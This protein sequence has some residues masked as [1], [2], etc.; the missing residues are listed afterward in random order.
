[1]GDVVHRTTAELNRG[2]VKLLADT[3]PGILVATGGWRSGKTWGI[4]CK[5]LDLSRREIGGAPLLFGAP[6]WAMVEQVFV[7]ALLR[8]CE[9]YKVHCEWRPHKKAVTLYKRHP[10]TIYCRSLDNPRAA[11]GLTVSN[12]LVDE[13]EL[14]HPDAIKTAKARITKGKVRQMVLAGTAEGYGPCYDL[15]LK[16]PSPTTRQLIMP[17]SGNADHI[18]EDYLTETVGVLDDAERAEKLEGIRQARGG[19]VY[20]RFNRAIHFGLTFVD[21]R[22]GRVKTE[23]W[24]DFNVGR[25]NWLIVDVDKET[26]RAHVAREVIGDETDTPQQCE[27]ATL[28]LLDHMSARK[29]KRVERDELRAMRIEAPCDASG[30]HRAALGSHAEAMRAAGFVPRYRSQNPAV[31]DRVFSVQAMLA[32]STLTINEERCSFLATAIQQQGR[33]KTTGEPEKHADPKRDLSGPMD[34]LG[35]GVYWHWPGIRYQ[36]NDAHLQKVKWLEEERIKA[37][38]RMFD[39]VIR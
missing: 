28:A 21:P 25:M 26:G 6:T 31:E 36:A 11:E 27:R 18:A 20:S 19:R 14:C 37:Q 24:C 4:A 9:L 38:E 33:N 29:G 17:T 35:Y 39:G 23:L 13:W 3:A 8:A 5:A 12:A 16:N 1:M 22:L 34:A 2:Q 15:I 32:R 30:R 10:H 7:E